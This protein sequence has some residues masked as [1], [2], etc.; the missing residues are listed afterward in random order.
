MVQAVVAL[1]LLG[2]CLVVPESPRWLLL[3]QDHHHRHQRGTTAARDGV[4][5]VAGDDGMDARKAVVMKALRWLEF[6]MEEARRD[7]FFLDGDGE[8]DEI[9]AAAAAEREQHQQQTPRIGMLQQFVLMFRS[10]Y[11]YRTL[12]AL[13]F[14]G[15]VQ[16]AGIDA[17][18]YYAPTLFT[19]A[20]ITENESTFLASGVSSITMLAVSIP[21]F[22]LTDQ[23]NR[24]TSAISGGLGLAGLMFLMGALYA[25]GAVTPVGAARWVVVVSVFLFGMVYCSTW[26]IVGKVYASEIQP[27][28][29]RAAANS[30]AMGLNF[31]S[32]LFL[33]FRDATIPCRSTN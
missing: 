21:A 22:L 1:A 29:T 24:R 32:S 23:W 26:G 12:L 9:V 13:L 11:R 27:G 8:G 16:L 3:H 6:D 5:V 28:N 33:L 31:V 19:Q 20:G 14:L 15:A 7:F 10:G 18:T 17:I 2:A 30:A 4:V 25:A